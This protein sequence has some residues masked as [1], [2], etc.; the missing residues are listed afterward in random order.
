MTTE[1]VDILQRLRQQLATVYRGD[2]TAIELMLVAL[3]TGGHVLLED[4]PGVGKTTLAKSLA[5]C[6]A[7][8]FARIQGT[9]DLMP[10]DITGLSIYNER[11]QAFHF[12]PGPIFADVLLVDELNRMPPRSQSALLEAFSEGQVS[13]DGTSHPLS[14]VFLCIATQNPHDQV[15]TYPLPESQMDRFLMRFSLGYPDTEAELSLLRDDGAEMALEAV[16]AV[17]DR[18]RLWQLRQEARQVRVGDEVRDYVLR[19]LQASRE[20]ESVRMGASPRAGLGLQR[21]AQAQAPLLARDFVIPEDIQSLAPMVLAHRLHVRSGSAGDTVQAL[22][23]RI[24]V[25]R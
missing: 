19:L 9:P 13:I 25:P 8:D 5:R 21:A 6:V 11:E 18:T 14:K 22:L 12:H 4:I 15:G 24:P 2:P 17:C 20:T 3:L 10:T 1:T 16:E 23:D 7:G